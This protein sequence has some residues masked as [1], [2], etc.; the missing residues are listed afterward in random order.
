MRTLNY[1]YMGMTTTDFN[2]VGKYRRRVDTVMR[3]VKVPREK[4][5]PIREKCLK[6]FGVVNKTNIAKTKEAMAV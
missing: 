2:R 5:S 6:L 1:E 4:G 3:E